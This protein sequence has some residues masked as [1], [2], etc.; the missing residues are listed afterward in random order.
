MAKNKSNK[1]PHYELL[2][3]VS[4][5]FTEDELKPIQE[6]VEKII[7]DNDG[8]ITFKENWGKKKLAYTIEHFNYGYYN[9]VEFDTKGLNLQ[10]INDTL[11]MSADIL[12]HQ[13]VTKA[14]LTT[15]EITK[16]KEVAEKLF[17]TNFAK[18][19]EVSKTS[20]SKISPK[21]K[22]S[23]KKETE[24]KVDQKKLD[25]KLEKILNTDDLL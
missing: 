19:E 17:K 12:R 23:N 18:K 21:P 14:K 11:R 16:E 5:K 24:E 3:I 25:E 20:T 9:L 10:K 22:T 1:V 13:I 15:S 7:T 2:Y 6:K 8:K 4:N